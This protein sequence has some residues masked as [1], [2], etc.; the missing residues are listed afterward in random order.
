M[1][2]AR[3]QRT[4]LTACANGSFVAARAGAAKSYSSLLSKWRHKW[5]NQLFV[6]SMLGIWFHFFRLFHQS[7]ENV[8]R[9]I[10]WTKFG[11]FWFTIFGC[12]CDRIQEK[13]VEYV[14][15]LEHMSHSVRTAKSWQNSGGGCGA[16]LWWWPGHVFWCNRYFAIRPYLCGC[17]CVQCAYAISRWCRNRNGENKAVKPNG[18]SVFSTKNVR[19]QWITSTHA[20][21]CE[22]SKVASPSEAWHMMAS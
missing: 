20:H 6:G 18:T 7:R 2:A 17:G 1:Q 13:S 12:L 14:A 3:L 19:W 15:F 21:I 9:M 4:L 16:R 11:H 8:A 5:I 10:V 22:R